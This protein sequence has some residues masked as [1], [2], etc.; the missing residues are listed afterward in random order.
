MVLGLFLSFSDEMK[1]H[2]T[3]LGTNMGLGNARRNS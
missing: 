2:F 3:E 1:S